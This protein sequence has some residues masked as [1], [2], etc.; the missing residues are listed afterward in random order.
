M[1]EIERVHTEKKRAYDNVVMNL[2][3]EKEKMDQDIK[4]A[5]TDYLEDERKYHQNNI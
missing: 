5:F 2:D 1:Q 3:Q 4:Q